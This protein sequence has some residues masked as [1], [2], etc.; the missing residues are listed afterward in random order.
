[1]TTDKDGKTTI[2]TVWVVESDSFDDDV[3]DI[4][5]CDQLPA[6]YSSYPNLTEAVATNQSCRRDKDNS[7]VWIVN[8]DFVTPDDDG[9]QQHADPT[10]DLPTIDITTENYQVAASDVSGADGQPITNSFGDPFEPQPSADAGRVIIRIK[11]NES[12][13]TDVAALINQYQD[14]VNSLDFWGFSSHKVKCQ[15]INSQ[16]PKSRN[17]PD[18]SKFFYLEMTYTFAVMPKRGWDLV[19]LDQGQNYR[20]GMGNTQTFKANDGVPKIGLLDGTGLAATGGPPIP[21]VFL[22]PITIYPTVDFHALGLPEAY[23]DAIPY[24]TGFVADF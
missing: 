3:T 20:D 19:L 22:S 2:K 15:N 5:A 8:I 17:L 9:Q 6:P 14:Y 16:G 11:R 18:G 21:P 23:T 7:T 10:Q 1:M 24:P 13:Q 4:M 12:I